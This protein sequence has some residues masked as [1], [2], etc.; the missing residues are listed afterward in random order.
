MTQ[1]TAIAKFHDI[2]GVRDKLDQAKY[3]ALWY[4]TTNSKRATSIISRHKSLRSTGK[5]WLEPGQGGTSDREVVPEDGHEQSWLTLSN[6]EKG[7]WYN[8]PSVDHLDNITVN[9]DDSN[10][11][12]MITMVGWQ[13]AVHAHRSGQQ[14]DWLLPAQ[15]IQCEWKLR[16]QTVGPEVGQRP[17][18]AKSDRLH[19]RYPLKIAKLKALFQSQIF[20]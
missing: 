5:V 11:S 17:R 12:Q 2:F 18:H 15:P 4:T 16:D 9:N 13:A 20:Y 1:T 14:S 8:F 10:F 7:T 3:W 19:N 6:A